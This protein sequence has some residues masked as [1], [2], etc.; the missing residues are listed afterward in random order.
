MLVPLVFH[1][2]PSTS[3]I[4]CPLSS[5]SHCYDRTTNF[6]SLY[7]RSLWYTAFHDIRRFVVDVLIFK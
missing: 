2:L 7:Q 4:P 5:I 6:L 3:S 1:S